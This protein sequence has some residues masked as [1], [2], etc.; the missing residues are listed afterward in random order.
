MAQPLWKSQEEALEKLRNGKILAGGVGSGKSRVAV[1][2][3]DRKTEC[4]EVVVITTAMKRDSKEWGKDFAALGLYSEKDQK[5]ITVDSWER[6]KNYTDVK[7]K[8]FIF[9]EQRVVGNGVWVKSFLKIT[10]NNEWILLSATPGDTW[11]DYIPVFVANGFYR[12]RTEF[13]RQHVVFNR[14]VRYPKVERYLGE[15]L[16]EQHRR[17]VLVYMDTPRDTVRNIGLITTKYDKELYEKGT[18]ERFNYFKNE[19]MRNAAELC[20]FQRRVVNDSDQRYEMLV[21]M[22]QTM[23][24][25]RVI[26]FYSFNYELERLRGLKEDLGVPVYER[27]GH[28]H[29]DFDDNNGDWVYLVQ[30]S[31]GS[32][33]WNCITTNVMFFYSRTYSWKVREQAMGRID[34]ANTPFKK[35]TYYEMSSDSS[36]DKAID[37]AIK[38]KMIFNEEAYVNSLRY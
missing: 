16:L 18:K 33:A 14:F 13:V 6:I 21:N 27:N 38:N 32:E 35:L 22:I 36:I 5:R 12:N 1:A 8:F 19:P 30:Y 31:S 2:Y 11:M 3:W 17:N 34:R 26:I 29:D 23:G 10:Q 7:D 15:K 20:Y 4:D 25:R 24:Y 37:R 28:R 9:D